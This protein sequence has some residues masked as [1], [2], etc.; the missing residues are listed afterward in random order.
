MLPGMIHHIDKCKYGNPQIAQGAFG[1]ISI[2]ILHSKDEPQ[3]FSFVAIKTIRNALDSSSFSSSSSYY[4]PSSCSSSSDHRS[5]PRPRLSPSV[6]T[7]LAALK[8]LSS[9]ND[10]HENITPLVSVMTSSHPSSFYENEISFVFPYC[11]MDLHQIIQ[12]HR[13]HKESKQIHLD[14]SVIR[15]ILGDILRGL[16][17]IHSLGIIHGDMKPGNILLDCNGIFQLA[18]FGLAQLTEYKSTTQHSDRH[19]QHL[20][21]QQPQGLCTLPYRPPEILF[22]SVH[23]LHSTSI[24]MW[25]VGLILCEMLSGRTLFYGVSVLDQLSKIMDVLGTPTR[26]SWQGLEDLPDYGKVVFDP[27][28]GLGLGMVVN[29]IQEDEVLESL[30]SG[31]VVMDP[32]KRKSASDCLKH[33]WMESKRGICPPREIQKK[34]IPDQFMSCYNGIKVQDFT[35]EMKEYLLEQMKLSGAEIALQRRKYRP[36]PNKDYLVDDDSL[37]FKVSDS[38]LPSVFSSKLKAYLKCTE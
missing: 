29:R 1:T 12:A 14:F 20:Q 3:Q 17:H 25:G 37:S 11:P 13:F 22:G 33:D 6:F 23:H 21:Q 31:L 34:F 32:S 26:E 5:R 30:V 36:G 15:T 7:E 2:A 4:R 38:S 35:D 18:D 27:R 24:D 8:I 9:P 19:I 10:Q 16:E 28:Q